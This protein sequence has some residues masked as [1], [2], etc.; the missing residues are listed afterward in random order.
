MFVRE[1]EAKPKE[2]YYADSLLTK[3]T[4][5][6]SA[7]ANLSAGLM[8][9]V[10]MIG[11]VD[12]LFE[13]RPEGNPIRSLVN[14]VQIMNQTPGMGWGQN[15]SNELS[16]MVGFGLNP[17]T[18]GF[19]AVGSEVAGAVG[20]G[21]GVVGSK[22]LPEAASVFMRRPLASVFG[23]PL[24]KYIPKVTVAG[25]EV[26]LTSQLLGEK[27]ADAFG[28]FAGAGVPQAWYD[29]Y[30]QDT[31]HIDWG[32]GATD[33][34]KMGAFG[35]A[36]QT[37]PFAWGVLKARVN[38]GLGKPVS[39]ELTMS[40]YNSAL[41]NGLITPEEHAWIKDY[42]E[43]PLETPDLKQRASKILADNDIDHN[44][45]THEVPVNIV[46]NDQMQNL[47]HALLD[48]S[49]SD[50]PGD[51]KS[52]LSDYIIRNSVDGLREKPNL[53][54][55]LR[56]YRDSV[57]NKLKFKSEK[58]AEADKMLD[59]HLTKSVKENMPFSQAEMFKT[60]KKF[61]FET[62]HIRNM[63]ITVP[64]NM[65]SMLR[66]MEEIETL[67]AKNKVYAKKIQQG[68]QGLEGKVSSNEKKIQVLNEKIPKLL[69]PK[70]ELEHLR[71]TLLTE[72]G[73]PKGYERSNAYNR[74]VDLSHVW[75]N[76]KT[77]L[78]RVLHEA[79]Y[80]KQEAFRNLADKV[81]TMADSNMGRFA[82]RGN[83]VNYLRDRIKSKTLRRESNTGIDIKVAEQK[84]V[85]ANAD[86]IMQMNE[87]DIAKSESKELA[88]EYGQ[89]ASKFK[90]FKSNENVFSN[91]IKC[92]LGGMNG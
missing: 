42:T 1:S 70:E 10:A 74:L 75:H 7:F 39:S 37:I 85:P 48:Q 6:E 43:N 18:W 56:G 16:N 19:G 91:L 30:N 58:L 24:G 63:P 17:I 92:V 84:E 23:E 46:D 73:L 88:K 38:R 40:D 77:L 22:V 44:M 9:P 31:R 68:R 35:L 29:N 66:R 47:N 61:G 54:D 55:G 32:G 4:S 79:D 89:I 26:P 3:P 14:S 41:E 8:T 27:Y 53:I 21:V 64:D 67:E 28:T 25:E 78:D 34:A 11:D 71:K 87:A 33:L 59:E 12:Q 49:V 80:E 51:V 69:T 81:L 82:E 52:S 57:D 13:Q 5:T 2:M 15:L 76:A 45:A 65:S 20:A 36:V 83:V 90:E 86:E 62:S 50:M 72:K 60:M